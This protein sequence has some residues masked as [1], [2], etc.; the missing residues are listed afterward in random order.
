METFAGKSF[1]EVYCKIQETSSNIDGIGCL[2]LYDLTAA[3]C[4]YHGIKIER[5]YVV[6]NGPK[7]AI[8]NLGIPEKIQKPEKLKYVEI[9]DLKRALLAKGYSLL[10]S[11]NGDDYENYICRL[12]RNF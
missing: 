12:Q 10:E 11:E 3:M 7:R 2:T 6:G 5:V 4:R 8:K 9:S 1:K